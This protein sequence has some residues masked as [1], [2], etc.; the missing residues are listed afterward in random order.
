M[1]SASAPPADFDPYAPRPTL[2]E[3]HGAS[4][5]AAVVFVLTIVLAVVS[6]PPF[7][8]PEFAYA[9]LVPGAFWAYTG[10]RLKVYAWTMLGAQAVAWTILLGWLHNVTWAGL[11][12]L[13]PFVGGWVGSWYLAAWWVLPRMVGRPTLTRLVAVLGLAGAWVLIEWTRT[14]L[15]GGFPWLPLAA[16]Q[17]ERATI[18]QISAWT[19]AQGVSFV[20]V[21]MNLGFAAYAHR[22]FREGATGLRKRSQEFFLALFLLLVCVSVHMQ[23]AFN[24]RGFAQPLG[25]VAL[26]QPAIPQDVKWDPAR[27]AGILEILERTTLDVARGRPAPDLIVWP[28]AVTP[29]AVRGD[30]SMQAFVEDVVKRA[31]APLLLG[32][33]AVENRGQP[34]EAWRNGAFVV[35]PGEG[36]AETAYAK[37]RLVPF[38]EFVPLRPV[39]GWLEKVVPVGGDF[40]AGDFASPLRLTLRGQAVDA[41][42]LICYEDIFP[43]LARASARAGAHVLVVVINNGWFGQGGAAYQHAA[44]AVLR[45][46]ETRRPVLRC[47]NSG[48]SGWIDEFGHVRA[49]VTDAQGSVYFRGSRTIEVTRDARWIDRQT[50][51]T[52]HGDWFVLVCAA[53]AVV[54]IAALKLGE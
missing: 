24:R 26:V 30:A 15:L 29:L 5:A 3:R 51:F 38:G 17:W 37:R 46:V 35:T 48:W 33:I 14:W 45:A 40:A 50:F 49:V 32:S 2:L 34:A 18:L 20:L 23:E 54:G 28:E 21:M 27:A 11:L 19:G 42:P 31:R 16:S 10:P 6:F 8:A 39:L 41:G 7:K 52:E 44:H 25:S 43:D 22:L 12:L 4:I 53:L 13:G 36:L 9:M 1:S 47:G